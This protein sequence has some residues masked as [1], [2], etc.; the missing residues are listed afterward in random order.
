VERHKFPKETYVS[1]HFAIILISYL[2][3]YRFLTYHWK[4]LEDSY[5]LIIGRYTLAFRGNLLPFL[6]WGQPYAW[7]SNSFKENVGATMFP[8]ETNVFETL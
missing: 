4:G 1:K 5:N 8:L 2:F 7:G 3:L 6:A